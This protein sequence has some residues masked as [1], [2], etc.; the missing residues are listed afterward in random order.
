MIGA[1]CAEFAPALSPKRLSLILNNLHVFIHYAC[2][3]IFAVITEDAQN[4]AGKG[5]RTPEGFRVHTWA[6]RHRMPSL[7][8]RQVLILSMAPP[9]G[10]WSCPFDLARVSPLNPKGKPVDSLSFFESS[11]LNPFT[12]AAPFQL[13]A[14]SSGWIERQAPLKEAEIVAEPPKEHPEKA[15]ELEGQ[16]RSPGFKSP[17]ARQAFYRI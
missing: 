14:R 2:S 1:S 6:L 8:P 15:V 16:C 3:A 12:L 4:G 10:W 5:I 7:C 17:R 9:A 11:R 13:W